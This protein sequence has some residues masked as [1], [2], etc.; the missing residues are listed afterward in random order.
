MNMALSIAHRGY[1]LQV[2]EV[3]LTGS[4]EELLGNPIIQKAYLGSGSA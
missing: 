4:A 1:V 2:A 3:V